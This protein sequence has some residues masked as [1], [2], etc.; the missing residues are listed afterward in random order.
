LCCISSLLSISI[1]PCAKWSKTGI[2]I[3]GT[4]IAGPDANQLNYP[5]GIFIQKKIKRL[6]V[7][8]SWNHRVQVF[9]LDRSTTTGLTVVSQKDTYYKIYV[10]DDNDEFPTIYVASNTDNRVKKWT[11]GATNGIHIG[12][13]CLGCT[14]V[15]LDKDKNVYMSDSEHCILKWSRL[16]NITTIVAGELGVGDASADHLNQPEGIVVDQTTG[17]LYIADLLNHRIQK[18]PKGALEGVTVAGSSDGNSGSDSS[19]LNRPYGLKVDEETKIVY[20]VDLMNSRIQ[21][22]IHGETEGDT[23]AGGN[24]MFNIFFIIEN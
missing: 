18:W 21:R 13:R 10:D 11:K 2:T 5:Q 8:D 20:V 9:P 7:S 17:A 12:D 23:I 19:L 16:T 4:G 22:W 24:G 3:A 6:Y 14:G 15:W 1:S